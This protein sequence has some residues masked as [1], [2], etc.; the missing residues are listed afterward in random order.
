MSDASLEFGKTSPDQRDISR[1]VDH[2]SDAH[3]INQLYSYEMQS[4][5]LLTKIKGMDRCRLIL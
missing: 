2:D 3:E 1:I 4:K 5:M